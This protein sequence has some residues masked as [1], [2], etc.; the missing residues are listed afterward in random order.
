[1]SYFFDREYYDNPTHSNELDASIDV[2][3]YVA[4]GVYVVDLKTLELK[5]HTHLDLS[6]DTVSYRA[7]IYSS[8]TLVDVDEG[9]KMEVVVGTSVGFLYVLRADGT[10]MTGFPPQMGEI[11]GQ[12]AAVD[13]GVGD[14]APSSSPRIPG[15]GGCF[16]EGRIRAVERHLASLIAQGASVGDVDGDGSPEVVVGTSSGA[17]HVLRGATAN[18][19]TPS[20]STPTVG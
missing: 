17:I 14:S 6:T 11:Q 20:R 18:R 5:W 12:V 8:P 16:S 10:T 3:K 19:C 15:F 9:R 1:M 7:Y 4:G 13:L 2:S